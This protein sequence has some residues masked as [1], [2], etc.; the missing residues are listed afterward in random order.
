MKCLK[1]AIIDSGID[2]NRKEWNNT[3]IFCLNNC[4]DKIGHGTA[5]ASIIAQNSPQAELYIYNLFEKTGRVDVKDLAKALEDINTYQHF[6]I[7]HLSCGVV[8]SD[9]IDELHDVIRNMFRTGTIFVAAF[10]NEGA[11]SYPAAFEEVIGVDW[12]ASCPNAAQYIYVKNSTINILGTGSLQRLPWLNNT[13]KYVAG[14][15]FSAPY[16]TALIS[17][18]M[19]DGISD[20][21]QILTC[22]EKKAYRIWNLNNTNYKHKTNSLKIKKAIIYPFNKEIHSIAINQDMLTFSIHGIYEPGLFRHVG[23]SVSDI[24]KFGNSNL[25][26]QNSKEINWDDD[27]DTLVLGHTKIMSMALKRDI[28]E[29]ML[30]YCVHYKKNIYSFD[31]LSAYERQISLL[32]KKGCWAYHPKIDESDVDQSLMGKLY[33]I[34]APVLGIFGTSPKQGKF[35]LQLAIKRKMSNIGYDIGGLASEPSALLF[36]FDNVYPM[37]YENSVYICGDKA[38]Q[39]IN[40]LMHEIDEKKHDL[41]LVGS[42]SQTIPYNMGNTGFYPLAQHE[43]LLGTEPDAVILC[44]N[45]FDEISYIKKTISYIE[46]YIDTKVVAI[47]LYPGKKSFEWSIQGYQMGVLDKQTLIQRKEFYMTNL[48]LPCFLLGS[49][50]ELEK[51]IDQITRFFT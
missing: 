8:A 48:Q 1:I 2:L 20:Y 17:N 3:K 35:T 38:V 47:S 36:G 40:R 16:I 13:Y 50:N 4:T 41:I 10:D 46:N 23:K 15:S 6:D 5:V 39:T 22:L 33:R 14:S 43:F 30:E 45:P 44:I 9:G 49:E 37:G 31:S 29:E 32:K 28:Q 42:Q 51:L 27:F 26:I 12:T 18:L 34:S 11:V 24:L 7:V 19:S 21:Q 25:I